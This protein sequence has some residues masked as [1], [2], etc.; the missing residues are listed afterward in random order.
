MA[1]VS[2]FVNASEIGKQID[3]S[4]NDINRFLTDNGLIIQSQ[5]RQGD[6]E[7]KLTAEG[8]KWGKEFRVGERSNGAAII[9][10]RWRPELAGHLLR[11]IDRGVAIKTVKMAV[12]NEEALLI[13]FYRQSPIEKR[14]ELLVSLNIGEK[15]CPSA[16]THPSQVAG[17]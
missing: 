17:Q 2:T 15:K 7:W 11:D 14:N 5:D 3:V 1:A 6:V 10:I 9:Q 13:E 16:P 4:R 12:T 8:Q